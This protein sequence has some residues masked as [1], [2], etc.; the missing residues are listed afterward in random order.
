[1]S[2]QPTIQE[3]SRLRQMVPCI[4]A[5]AIFIIPLLITVI[6][7][8]IAGPITAVFLGVVGYIMVLVICVLLWWFERSKRKS[9]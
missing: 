8:P 3:E 4:L 1:M 9:S 7:L 6:V 5:L 2:K